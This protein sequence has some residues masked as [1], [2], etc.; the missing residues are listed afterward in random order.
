MKV[1]ESLY[2][3]KNMGTQSWIKQ[4]NSAFPYFCYGI[5]FFN[6]QN[7]FKKTN[8]PYTSKQPLMMA[9]KGFESARDYFV[10][11][12][13]TVHAHV[14]LVPHWLLLTP[15]YYVFSGNNIVGFIYSRVYLSTTSIEFNT[16][17]GHGDILHLFSS[18]SPSHTK[19]I[20]MQPH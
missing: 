18:H 5:N 1:F 19:K 4:G 15:T 14:L 6:F 11:V 13:F 17:A 9:Y 16:S 8:T 12:C 20:L 7:S 10:T 3:N 2:H